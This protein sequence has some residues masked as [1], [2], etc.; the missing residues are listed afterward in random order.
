M[1]KVLILLGLLC[2]LAGCGK[3]SQD[4][5]INDFVKKVNNSK[6]YHL[7]GNLEIYRDEEL[8]TYSID[9]SYQE[10]DNFRVSLINQTNNHEQIILKNVDGVYVV[11]PSLN[12]SFKFQSEWPYNNSQIYLLQPIIRDLQNDSDKKFEEKDDEYIFT[13]KVNYDNDTKLVKQK[14][15]LDKKLNLTKVEVLDK[16][17]NVKMR[18]TIMEYDLKASFDDKY[19]KL[20]KNYNNDLE[21]TKE[22]TEKDKDNQQ[23][24]SESNSSDKNVS[25]K[26]ESSNTKS[27]ESNSQSDESNNQNIKSSSSTINEIVYP[28]YVPVNTY[29]A[30]QDK[31]S[32]EN[33]ERVIL[34]FS[35]ET[36]FLLVQE[37]ASLNDTTDFV[38]GDPYLILDTI[39]AVTDYSVSWINDGVEYSVVSDTMALDE[40]IT[41]AES[42]STV[43]VGK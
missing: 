43:N 6:C 15:Y 23:T 19:F 20:G 39:G 3:Y 17:D 12:K 16:N 32:T 18:L 29:L 41:V 42:I 40:L 31:V 8:Y 2:C 28:M 34:T 13:V 9:S 38:N 22:D 25:D 24:K 36:P 37:T 4:D 26:D 7:T 30:N 14:I 10:K 27:D 21:N 35:G 33:G 5:I 1:K 11:T